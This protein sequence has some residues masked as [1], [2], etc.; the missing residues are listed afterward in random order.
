MAEFVV[1][2]HAGPSSDFGL[3]D[4]GG[5]AAGAEAGGDGGERRYHEHGDRY[6]GEQLPERLG[7]DPVAAWDASQCASLAAFGATGALDG[8][9]S[10]SSGERSTADYCWDLTT[11]ALV[12]SWDLARGIGADE[13]LDPELVELVWE[14]TLPI[15]AQLQE[16]GLFAPAVPV[17]DNAALQTKMLA[18][19]GRRS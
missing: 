2:H 4:L 17:A 12:H 8:T 18:L 10:L 3:E 5:G 16:T 7:A 15:A 19:F 9:V 13:A 6:H 14:R 1:V 11:D